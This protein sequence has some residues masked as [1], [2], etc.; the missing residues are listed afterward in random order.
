MR[1]DDYC[2]LLSRFEG[3]NIKID[4][5][6]GG[7]EGRFSVGG[8][9]SHPEEGLVEDSEADQSLNPNEC[10][11]EDAV[12][13]FI[14]VTKNYV[15]SVLLEVNSC[16]N[17]ANADEPGVSFDGETSIWLDSHFKVSQEDLS[18]DIDHSGYYDK[19]FKS[20]DCGELSHRSFAEESDSGRA[21][22]SG[23][24][25]MDTTDVGDFIQMD[26]SENEPQ[27]SVDTS[28][29]IGK[30]DTSLIIEEIGNDSDD[31]QHDLTKD[32][33]CD[34]VSSNDKIPHEYRNEL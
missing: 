29:T 34:A 23:H 1:V 19:D 31:D 28:L 8:E 2:R 20:D 7:Q 27:H 26:V 16:S 5:M 30:V 10:M 12:E 18:P 11:N 32:D 3:K 24:E 4:G 25:D 22:L 13:H 33:C 21:H 6:D 15:S 9:T 14:T 17:I